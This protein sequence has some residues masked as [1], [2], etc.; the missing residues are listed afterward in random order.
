MFNQNDLISSYSRAEAISDG[1][2]VDISPI[3]SGIKYPVAMTSELYGR[4]DK[5][6]YEILH[7]FRTNAPTA[8]GDVMHFEIL[9]QSGHFVKIKSVIGP[10][11]DLEPVITLMLPE[12]D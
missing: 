5:Y 3:A 6:I 11:D 8:R 4:M 12:E 9:K 1:V 2:L 10:G 7:A